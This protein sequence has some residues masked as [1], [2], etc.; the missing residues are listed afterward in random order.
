MIHSDAVPPGS[1]H[2]KQ[3]V[4]LGGLSKA[5]LPLIPTEN[6]MCGESAV[7]NPHAQMA[8]TGNCQYVFEGRV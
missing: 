5:D 6:F 1:K 8:V 7:A 2:Q 4:S 3:L